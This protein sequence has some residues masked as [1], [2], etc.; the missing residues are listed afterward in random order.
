MIR[1]GKVKQAENG[2]CVWGVPLDQKAALLLETGERLW[3]CE[4]SAA[5]GRLSLWA[6]WYVQNAFD[7]FPHLGS[8][9]GT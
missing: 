5:A 1:D 6:Q 3:I 9:K 7:Q 8:K 4:V 2:E